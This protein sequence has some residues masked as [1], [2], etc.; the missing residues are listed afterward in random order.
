VEEPKSGIQSANSDWQIFADATCAGL[1]VLIPL[2]LVDIAFETIFRRRI[3]ATIAKL[4]KRDV[5]P[6]VRR[7]LGRSLDGPLHLPGCAAVGLAAVKYVLRRV[8]RKIIYFLAVKDATAALTEYWHRAFLIDHMVRAA[9]LDPEA[10]TDLAVRVAMG[11]LR[12]IDPSPL[13]GMARQ[14]VASV[15]HVFRLLVRARR[16]GA[17]EVTRGLGDALSSHWLV[18]RLSLRATATLYDER[19]RIAVARPGEEVRPD[20]R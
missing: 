19:Y 5:V 12:D 4:R 7:Q 16:L 1:S 18:A 2:P 9:H 10:D 8:W 13:M 20:G 17:T 3:P 6:D 14:T 15:H 11:V